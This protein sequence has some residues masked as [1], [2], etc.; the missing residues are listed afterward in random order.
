MLVVIEFKKEKTPPGPPVELRLAEEQ[1]RSE[2]ESAGFAIISTDRD[3]L[4]FQYI[5]KAH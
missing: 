5:I 2:V 4:P 3:L 1:V